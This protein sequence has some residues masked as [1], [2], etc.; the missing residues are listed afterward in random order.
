MSGP[1][2]NL[3]GKIRASQFP[4]NSKSFNTLTPPQVENRN[5]KAGTEFSPPAGRCAGC[6]IALLS[7]SIPQELE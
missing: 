6:L 1:Y 3:Q 2:P 4:S 5:R 7:H